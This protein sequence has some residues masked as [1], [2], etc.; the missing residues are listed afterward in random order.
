MVSLLN[1][2][3]LRWGSLP[4]GSILS[5]LL[6]LLF[7]ND[8]SDVVKTCTVNLYADDTMIYSTDMNT[9]V[10]G[11]MVEKDLESVAVWIEMNGLKMNVMKTQLMVVTEKENVMWLHDSVNVNINGGLCQIPWSD[12]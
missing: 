4:Q 12:A 8:L 9:K 2:L 10:L 3:K 1:G 5:P 7:V 6:F 11:A